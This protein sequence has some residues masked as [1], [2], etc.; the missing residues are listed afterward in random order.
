M[1]AIRKEETKFEN[2]ELKLKRTILEIPIVDELQQECYMFYS[3]DTPSE[4]KE[5]LLK[6]VSDKI[7]E[8]ILK[9]TP[10]NVDKTF[11][12]RKLNNIKII[13]NEK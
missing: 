7:D 2:G 4:L 3:I 11:L 1:I 12:K 6:E 10:N 5:M 13:N 8:I 9:D